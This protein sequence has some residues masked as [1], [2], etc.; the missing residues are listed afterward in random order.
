MLGYGTELLNMKLR[1]EWDINMKIKLNL[2]I[3]EAE[4]M[5]DLYN[6]VTGGDWYDDYKDT[7]SQE[8]LAKNVLR[9][10]ENGIE[11]LDK[12]LGTTPLKKK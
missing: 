2:T 11:K 10:I 5:L 8:N 1:G 12:D 3:F 4:Q 9:K 6:M 7:K